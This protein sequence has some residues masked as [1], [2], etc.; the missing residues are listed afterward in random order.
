MCA[1]P[2]A[3][4]S[5]NR[6]VEHG[7]KTG[8][9]VDI[10]SGGSMKRQPAEAVLDVNDIPVTEEMISAYL[11]SLDGKDLTAATRKQYEMKL[12]K[13]YCDLPED[14]RI[15]KGVLTRWRTQMESVYAPS[16]VNATLS[17]VNSFL[18]WLTGRKFPQL[19]R[20]RERQN[21]LPELTRQE[22]YRLL[23]SAIGQNNERGYLL[24]KIFATTGI[25]V[26]ELP[27]VTVESVREGRV[28]ERI[29]GRSRIVRIPGCLREELLSY[30]ARE[31]IC[32]GPMFLT[33]RQ[34]SMDR[35]R[36]HACIQDLCQDAHVEMEKG[37]PRCL[38][39][40]YTEAQKDMRENL[41]LILEQSYDRMLEMEQA[42]VGWPEK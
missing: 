14:K 11:E 31:Q 1:E 6:A 13:F 2:A 23:K 16:T 10:G 19:K 33:R 27:K 5:L 38:R 3:P 41:A 40:L 22:Y 32:S 36:V 25:A 9:D 4:E 24:V 39:R 42:S 7:G 17:V 30:A 8:K 20:V 15:E 29:N 12:W 37:N 35:S 26:Q 21:I 28:A 34:N 18:E